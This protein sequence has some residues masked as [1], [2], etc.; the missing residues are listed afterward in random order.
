ME[1][2]ERRWRETWPVA[3]ATWGRTS[4]LH[5]PVLHTDPCGM[6]SWAWYSLEDVEVHVDLTVVRERH[7]ED[8]ALAVL[9][10][11]IGHHLLA[12]VDLGV[13]RAHR[14]AR[15]DRARR[16]RPPGRARVEPV[17]R[18]ADQRPAAAPARGGP[19]GA[20]RGGRPAR[21]GRRA[22][23]PGPAHERDPLG[24]G[25]AAPW[26][27]TT[28]APDDQALLCARLVRAYAR[29]PVGGAAGFAALVRSTIP[30]EQLRA[31]Q[32]RDVVACGGSA[33][34]DGS[35]PFG[36]ATDPTLGMPAVHPSRDPRVVGCRPGRGDAPRTRT[37]P[38]RRPPAGNALMPGRCTPCCR[39]SASTTTAEEVAIAWYR[40][41]AARHLV[42]FPTRPRPRRADELLAGLEPWEVGDD[43]SD[44][45][46][47]GHGD[48]VARRGAGHDDRAPRRT[49]T[50]REEIVEARPVDLDLYLDSSGLDARPAPDA[51]AHRAGRGDPR[52]LGAAGRRAGAGHDVERPEPGGGDG[53]VH[54]RR[55]RGPA[56]GRR[57]LRRWHGLPARP[58]APHPPRRSRR[59]R[60]AHAARSDPHRRH[61]GRRHRDHVPAATGTP[62]TRRPAEALRAADGGGTLVL[63]VP[64]GVGRA[65]RGVGP[66]A[67]PCTAW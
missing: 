54:A 9:A 18:P 52:P 19:R 43:L 15:P 5:A 20:V 53:R 27:A 17:V 7:V 31:Q 46:L 42:P 57:V 14:R 24:S 59:R 44:R 25:R 66:T 50:T 23:A 8:H 51:R 35:V 39:R 61:L 67:T 10:H 55:G 12:P 40:E 11:E 47:D 3:L 41:H 60:R 62:P 28:R 32:P 22:H 65:L 38:R 2:V 16:P 6:P 29:D 36:V 49:W 58:A 56:G 13:A 1:D 33:G 37:R 34:G 30:V 48:G 45:R 4:R 64:P 21:P 63:Q 26:S